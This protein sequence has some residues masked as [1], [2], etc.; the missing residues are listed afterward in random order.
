MA[1]VLDHYGMSAV[2]YIE[3]HVTLVTRKGAARL[4]QSAEK[5]GDDA[6]YWRIF[7]KAG[8]HAA[9]EKSLIAIMKE[10]LSRRGVP[11]GASAPNAATFATG[12]LE[13]V[14]KH[15]ARTLS[16]RSCYRTSVPGAL[17]GGG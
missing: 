6:L 1:E 14:V 8:K 2:P 13:R 3:H 17:A 4:L 5:L 11:P 12:W 16:A 7:F 9:W 15:R 10:A